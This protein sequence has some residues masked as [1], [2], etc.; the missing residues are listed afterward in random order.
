MRA[1]SHAD[2]TFVVPDNWWTE[3]GMM[4]FVPLG[5]TYRIGSPEPNQNLENRPVVLIRHIDVAPLRRNLSHGVFNDNIAS[6]TARERV[7][8]I[9][10]G[11]K[12]EEGIPPILVA[13]TE[14]EPHR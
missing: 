8:R 3:A 2:F 14:D 12:L 11:F 6:G 4:N 9:L 10:R 7:L 13:R 1:F 5:Q